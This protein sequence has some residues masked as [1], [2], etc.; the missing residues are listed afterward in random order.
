MNSV[1]ADD[2]LLIT[3]SEDVRQETLVS[4][5]SISPA[6]LGS[7]VRAG[8][9]VFAFA[10]ES[11]WIM[12]Q[13]Y[14]LR[15]EPTVQDTSG[16]KLASP[17]QVTFTPDIPVQSVQSIKTVIDSSEWTVFNTPDAKPVTINVDGDLQLVLHF[18]EPFT[19][20]CGARL[21]SAI[22]LDGYFPSSL[23]DPSLTF[24]SWSGGVE[25]SLAYTGLQKSTPG[26]VNYYKLTLP[27]GVASLDNGSGSF[28]KEDV[29]LYFIT[30]Q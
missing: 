11:R 26:T 17:Y 18:V 15:I 29:W 1:K 2:A 23:S 22:T 9:G 4:A 25:L 5:F 30:N 16:N 21:V 3:F 12:S 24:A 8:P 10:P 7:W 19:A 28:L 14:T 20:E 13:P 27:G 6:T